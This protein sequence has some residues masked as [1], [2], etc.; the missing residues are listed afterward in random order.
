MPKITRRES[1]G[2][3]AALAGGLALS[4]GGVPEFASAEQSAAAP[5]DRAPDL[6][7]V[8]ATV[9]TSD[10]ARPRAEAKRA[11]AEGEMG[12]VGVRGEA[13]D[14]PAT[15]ARVAEAGRVQRDHAAPGAQRED[16]RFDGER[17]GVHGA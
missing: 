10:P 15:G 7:V 16:E 3:G 8:N 4:R 17:R 5:P 6:V 11:P 12:Q 2:F 9:Y 13:L 1:L 14:S